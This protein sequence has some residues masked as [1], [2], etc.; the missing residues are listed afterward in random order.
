M[1]KTTWSI[2]ELTQ[3]F[4]ITP[5]SI[6]F[7][8]DQGL[9]TPT[10]Q[11][12]TRIYSRQDR[13]RLKLTLRGKRLGFSLAEIRELFSFYDDTAHNNDKQLEVMIHKVHDKLKTLELQLEDLRIVQSELK[14][15]EQRCWE[16]MSEEGRRQLEDNLGY[17]FEDSMEGST[18]PA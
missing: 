2:S 1:N 5:R 14:L 15:A 3:E 16:S 13:V 8:E 12:Q 10:R 17:A 7:Y 6:R 9:L 4:G 18:T 11:G